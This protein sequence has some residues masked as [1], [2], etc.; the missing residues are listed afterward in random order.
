MKSKQIWA[1]VAALGLAGCN[2]GTTEEAV[3]EAPACI[4]GIEVTGG[5]MAMGAIPGDPAAVYFSIA[6]NDSTNHMIRAA[7]VDGAA[8]AMIHQMGTW[9]L[10]PSMDEV[11]Q[12]DI[13]A[14]ETLVFEPGT[15]HVMAMEPGEQLAPGGQTHVTLTFVGGDTCTF[16]VE[17]HAAGDEPHHAE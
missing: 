5:W 12:L 7:A 4:P 8:S 17:I 10:Q 13:P 3:T 11:M 15:Y 2:T 14:G 9:S 6:N 1:M 16:P